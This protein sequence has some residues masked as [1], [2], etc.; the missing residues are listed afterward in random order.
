MEL[1]QAGVC[2]GQ[3]N[4]SLSCMKEGMFLA[5]VAQ[6]FGNPSLTGV[7]AL[8][9]T[10]RVSCRNSSVSWA[11]MRVPVRCQTAGRLSRRRCSHRAQAAKAERSAAA[12]TPR[13]ACGRADMGCR[14]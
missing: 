13:L 14:A 4:G 10:S 3:G 1:K 12:L 7:S 8:S 2:C 9:H 6:A 11:R 5:T